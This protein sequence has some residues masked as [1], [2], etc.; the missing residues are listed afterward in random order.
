MQVKLTLNWRKNCNKMNNNIKK[1]LNR[2][3][4][5]KEKEKMKRKKT[6]R[7][8]RLTSKIYCTLTVVTSLLISPS[9]FLG[10]VERANTQAR[11]SRFSSCVTIFTKFEQNASIF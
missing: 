6:L 3:C 9:F 8:T 10:I 7:K 1:T 2:A 11:A 4:Y 5:L